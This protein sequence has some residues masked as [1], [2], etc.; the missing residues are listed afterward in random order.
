MSGVIKQRLKRIAN[1]E[2]NLL[3]YDAGQLLGGRS[4]SAVSIGRTCC[5][6]CILWFATY[7]PW[8]GR[9]YRKAPQPSPPHNAIAKYT[10]SAQ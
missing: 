4:P 6:P 8:S 1:D 7:L 5:H 10:C 3:N 9:T 2:R